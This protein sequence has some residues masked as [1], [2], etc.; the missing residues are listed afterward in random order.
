[1]ARVDTVGLDRSPMSAAVI[2]EQVP[3]WDGCSRVSP[4]QSPNTDPGLGQGQ[5]CSHLGWT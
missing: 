1:M 4:G 5:Y 3:C 2:D